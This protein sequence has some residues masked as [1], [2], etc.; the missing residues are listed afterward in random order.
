MSLA[1]NA[2]STSANTLSDETG[3]EIP[4]TTL[5]ADIQEPVTLIKADIEGHEQRALLGPKAIS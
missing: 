5:D 3:G 1:V 2:A 4:V